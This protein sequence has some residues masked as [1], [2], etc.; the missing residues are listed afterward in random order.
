MALIAD[1]VKQVWR[2]KP[3]WLAAGA[4]S[5]GWRRAL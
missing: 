1:A 4:T 5:Y 2:A 3:G